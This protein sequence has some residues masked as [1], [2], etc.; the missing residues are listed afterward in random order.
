VT[1]GFPKLSEMLTYIASGLKT[2]V[3]ADAEARFSR[4]PSSFVQD[5][6]PKAKVLPFSH[7]KRRHRKNHKTMLTRP[8]SHKEN[9]MG[10]FPDSLLSFAIAFDMRVYSE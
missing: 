10:G 5:V 1:Q 6:G 4:S 9:R 2:N 3:L 8:H 7:V